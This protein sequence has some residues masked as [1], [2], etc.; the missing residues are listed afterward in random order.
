MMSAL[1]E[2]DDENRRVVVIGPTKCGKSTLLR[3]L[4]EG[5]NA[6]DQLHGPTRGLIYLPMILLREASFVNCI[7]FGGTMSASKIVRSQRRIVP[8]YVHM[9][10][11]VYNGDDP[12]TFMALFAQWTDLLLELLKS[13]TGSK[14]ILF[15]VETHAIATRSAEEQEG[16]VKRAH[17]YERWLSVM[18]PV[19]SYRRVCIDL[20][21]SPPTADAATAHRH[22]AP[23]TAQFWSLVARQLCEQKKVP[24]TKQRS[25]YP[26]ATDNTT[27]KG[28]NSNCC[29]I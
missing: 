10:L 29:L 7:E 6:S 9:I 1:N 3:T 2:Y 26:V 25:F 24:L 21:F 11:L 17:Q 28:T 14:P 16:Y 20:D 13:N 8:S 4:Y 5:K 22:D 19:G 12:M 15:I 18:L 23:A 27:A